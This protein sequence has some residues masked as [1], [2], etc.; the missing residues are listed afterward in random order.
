MTEI[1]DTD[2][3]CY[4]ALMCLRTVI[5]NTIKSDGGT[6][7]EPLKPPFPRELDRFESLFQLVAIDVT[8]RDYATV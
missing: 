5:I 6:A 1:L 7:A 2:W 3:A 8:F 4:R